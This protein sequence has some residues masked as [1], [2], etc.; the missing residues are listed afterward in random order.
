ME[1]KRAV[2]LLSALAQAT[3]LEIFRSLVASGP[4][5]L[6]AGEIAQRLS[7]PPPTLSFHLKDLAAAELVTS[8]REG[9]SIR[10]IANFNAI[11]L[12]MSFLTEN[13]C[14]GRP[15]DCGIAIEGRKPS[16]AQSGKRRAVA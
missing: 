7:V 6:P 1:N 2:A 10:Y 11:S 3:R 4:E 15:D 5:G 13:C 14:G 8:I 9:R 16:R 12:L